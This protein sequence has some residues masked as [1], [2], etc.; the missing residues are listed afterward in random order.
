LGLRRRTSVPSGQSL[1][2]LV[3]LLCAL[4]MWR[5]ALAWR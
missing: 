2:F 4:G 3:M 1:P 5:W